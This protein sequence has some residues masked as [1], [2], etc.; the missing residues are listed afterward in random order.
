M[1]LLSAFIG[2]ELALFGIYPKSDIR[3]PKST[4]EIHQ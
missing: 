4:S 2:G 1:S 3:N